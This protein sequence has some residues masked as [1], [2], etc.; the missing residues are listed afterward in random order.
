MSVGPI[1]SG[2]PGGVVRLVLGEPGVVEQ[3]DRQARLVHPVH[4]DVLLD[5][6]DTHRP[7]PRLP[8]QARLP[9]GRAPREPVAAGDDH[10]AQ[11]EIERPPLE[12]AA[13]HNGSTSMALSVI[14]VQA[15]DSLMP[16]Y[17]TP[18][19]EGPGP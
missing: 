7:V 6:V 9:V 11:L 17:K 2:G 14:P 10:Q 13:V 15:Y 1:V 3:P 8:R 16:A 18:T 5:G 12:R 4:D 19:L